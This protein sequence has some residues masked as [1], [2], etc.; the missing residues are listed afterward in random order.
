MIFNNN[1]LLLERNCLVIYYNIG[2]NKVDVLLFEEFRGCVINNG[3]YN[4]LG[5]VWNDGIFL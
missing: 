5:N 3:R 2:E 4:Y 1:L